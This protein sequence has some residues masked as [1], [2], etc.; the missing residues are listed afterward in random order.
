MKKLNIGVIGVGG[1]GAL[2]RSAHLPSEGCRLAAGADV[3]KKSLEALRE[4]AGKDVFTTNDYRR[5]L[6]VKDIDAVF[7]ASPDFLHEEHCVASLEAGKAVYLEKPM[8]ITIEGCDRILETAY[9]T[10]SKL[11]LGHNM[12]HFASILKMKEIIDSGIIGDVQACWCRHF[13]G[14][15]GDAYFRDWHSE[16]KN[17]TGLLLQKGAHD[18]DVIHWLMGAYTRSVVGMGML[19]VYDKCERRPEGTPGSAKWDNTQYPPLTQK[20][21][22]P[23][24]DIED[25]NMIMMQL[26]NGSQASYVQ[27]HYTPDSERNY[28]FIGTNG[29]IE[30][31]GDSGKCEIHVWTQR[32]ERNSP[33][34]VHHLKP[35]EGT[36]GGSDPAI[37]RTFL[38]FVRNGTSTNTSPVAARYSVAVGVM[39]H[40]SM[41][42]GCRLKTIPKLP[43]KLVEYFNNGQSQPRDTAPHGKMKVAPAIG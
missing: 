12:R 7:I 9:N 28:T 40:A 2:A 29:R 10:G 18:I 37:V 21:F 11:F 25:H 6:E 35:I 32:G 3:D 36:H 34:I 31:V 27:C 8:A 17:T 42:T 33:D 23:V 43:D 39:G 26:D 38:D 16:R 4:F 5:L 30:N 20:G 13:I 22:S 19:S 14:Y 15:G 24:I 41:R 1:R